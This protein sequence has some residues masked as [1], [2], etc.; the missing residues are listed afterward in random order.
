M[1]QPQPWTSADTQAAARAACTAWLGVAYSRKGER[2]RVGG[3]HHHRA[4]VRARKGGGGGWR[5][6]IPASPGMA[7]VSLA[8]KENKSRHRQQAAH[9]RVP[10]FRCTVTVLEN[11]RGVRGREGGGRRL[12]WRLVHRRR[13][14]SWGARGCADSAPAPALSPPRV[15]GLVLNY[16]HPL[17]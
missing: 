14:C 3:R 17:F 15:H 11:R 4:N 8:G 13:T 9:V 6:P 16:P 1:P 7:L 10:R 2:A 12:S 5:T